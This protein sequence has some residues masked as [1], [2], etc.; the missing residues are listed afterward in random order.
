[1]THALEKSKLLDTH[2]NP[3]L[4]RRHRFT[5]EEYERAYFAGAFGDKRV[6]LI[7]GEIIEMPPMNDPHVNWLGVLTR[8]L[9][10]AFHDLAMVLPQ[11]PV[12]LEE[13]RSQPEPDFV[14]VALS[15]YE[16]K[17]VYVKDAAIVIEISD[18][19][20]EEDRDIKLRLYARNFAREFWILNVRT[21]Q[22]EVY[23]DPEGETY[24]TKFTL[25]KGQVVTPLEFPQ[26][27]LE[28]WA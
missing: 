25:S 2:A 10:L 7:E 4:N 19:I 9:V 23:R 15:K 13:L 20:L 28:W 12:K 27:A 8:R 21:Q 1:M 6:E 26:I 22:L 18:S 17:K 24:K 5:V 16:Q 3:M 11:V 14:I